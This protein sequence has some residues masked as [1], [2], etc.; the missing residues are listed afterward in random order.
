MLPFQIN[1]KNVIIEKKI[2][3]GS[4]ANIYSAIDFSSSKPLVLKIEKKSSSNSTIDTEA[5]ILKSLFKIQGVPQILWS[6]KINQR[7]A[8]ITD[9]L[10][11]SLHDYLSTLKRFS[12]E[13]LSKMSVQLLTILEQ[14]HEQGFI[15]KDIKPSNI[16][17]GNE[18]NRNSIYL[19]D[20]NLSKRFL[21]QNGEHIP[22]NRV[23]EFNGNL[24]F[25]SVNTHEFLENSRKDDLESLGYVLCFL[26]LGKMGWDKISSHDVIHKIALIGK[27]KRNFLKNVASDPFL[28]SCLKLYFENVMNIGFYDKP[29]YEHLRQ[30]FVK[31]A[32]N[33]AINLKNEWEWNL[34]TESRQKMRVKSHRNSEDST[35]LTEFSVGTGSITTHN[36]NEL[37]KTINEKENIEE[38]FSKFS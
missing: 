17:I 5:T 8:F 27:Y 29:N 34:N 11:S 2:N 12:L 23:E 38:N 28:P 15:H 10:G 21:D 16:L 14:I 32:E 19:I 4:F 33:E 30:I 9:R 37:K 18:N 20:F 6:G 31:F 36:S 24:Q 13:T 26:F 7:S 1:N 35:N 22:L 25:S 3:K